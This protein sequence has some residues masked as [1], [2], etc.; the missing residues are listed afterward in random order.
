MLRRPVRLAVSLGLLGWSATALAESNGFPTPLPDALPDAMPVVGGTAVPAGKWPDTV[1]VLGQ[2]ACTGT[3]IA[4]DVVLTAGHCVD[5]QMTQ[6]IVNTT[7]YNSPG[8][9]T[10][11]IKS[12]T[13]YPN[14]ENSYDVA[15]IVLNQPATG[16][17]PRRIGV[18]CTFEGFAA[19][20]PVHLVG[21]G[22]TTQQ[23]NQPNSRLNEVT[24]PVT[25]PTC[26]GNG[27]NAAGCVAAVAPG[28]EFIAGG[29]NRD[30]C[31]GDSGGPVYLDTPRGT[32]VIGAVSRGLNNSATPCGGGGIY[33]RTDKIVQWIETTAGKAVSKDTC[34][35]PPP[36][37]EEPKE[38]EPPSGGGDN[39]PGGGGNN[40]PPG[41]DVYGDVYGG[42]STSGG[43]GGAGLVALG[44]AF[45]VTR[46]RRGQKAQD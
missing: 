4:P 15:V 27:A 33:V 37:P 46:R 39:P 2:G 6:V 12:I 26:S 41:G 21:F 31:F 30:S 19:Q 20:M 28:G 17:T 1:A 32:V 35:Q 25:N 13:A 24:A 16:V 36:P 42:C 9:Q 38:E 22:A 23:G 8:G 3:L 43:A 40:N 29:G 34:D 10:I 14:W 7:N 44:L 11:G 18:A 5:A 45:A